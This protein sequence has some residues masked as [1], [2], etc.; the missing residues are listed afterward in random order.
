MIIYAISGVVFLFL[1]FVLEMILFA[2]TLINNGTILPDAIKE[3]EEV[4]EWKRNKMM[5]LDH[6]YDK[7]LSILCIIAWPLFGLFIISH[8]IVYRQLF[9]VSKVEKE[10]KKMKKEIK[11]NT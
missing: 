5:W 11:K 1:F 4:A 7:G 3:L 10:I 8:Y 9:I 6:I 2:A